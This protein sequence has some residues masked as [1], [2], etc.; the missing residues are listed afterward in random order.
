M[1]K[2]ENSKIKI[3]GDIF[4]IATPQECA[5]DFNEDVIDENGVIY[6]P[7]SLKNANFFDDEEKMKDYFDLSKEEFLA[8]YS[9][10]TEEEYDNTDRIINCYSTGTISKEEI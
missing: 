2:Y 7:R 3:W 9:Y 1:L 5:D 6:H 10:L 8:S 4:D